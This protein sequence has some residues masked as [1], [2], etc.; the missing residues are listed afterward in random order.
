MS[1][2]SRS[3]CQL[4]PQKRTFAG[5]AGLSAKCQERTSLRAFFDP[6]VGLPCATPRGTCSSGRW[7]KGHYVQSTQ[8]IRWDAAVAAAIIPSVPPQHLLL[9][10]DLRTKCDIRR[11][12]QGAVAV[13]AD[14]TSPPPDSEPQNIERLIC[15]RRKSRSV[16]RATYFHRLIEA[17]QCFFLI[18]HRRLV[19]SRHSRMPQRNW[20]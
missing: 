15:L 10:P 19:P 9:A 5:A 7:Y 11:E 16:D 8:S 4:L 18:G 12:A 2:R 20:D 13:P 1:A 17:T 6:I 3:R 14:P